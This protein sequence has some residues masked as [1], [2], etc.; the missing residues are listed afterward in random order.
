MVLATPGYRIMYGTSSTFKAGDPSSDKHQAFNPMI[1][2]IDFPDSIKYAIEQITTCN[3]LYPNI[4][5]DTKLEEGT[6]TFSCHFRDPILFS[7]LFTYKGLPTSWTGSGDTMTFDFSNLINKDVNIWV[8]YHVED[9]SGESNHLDVLLDGGELV[10]YKL[11][12]EGGP[13]IEEFEIKFATISVATETDS[14]GAYAI[15]IDDGFDDGSFDQTGVAEI[16]TVVAK[17]K[18]SL[19]NGQYFKLWKA[20]GSGGWTAYYAYMDVTGTEDGDPAPTGFTK[21]RCNI[22]GDTT[23]QNV[24][25]TITAAITA[26]SG[27]TAANGGGASET[28]TIT[29]DNTGDIKNIV[30]VDTTMTVAVLTQGVTALDGG[31]SL[32]DGDYTSTKCAMGS[33]AVVTFGGASFTDIDIQKF[34]MSFDTPKEPYYVSNSLIVK[35]RTLEVR[36]PWAGTITGQLTKGNINMAQPSTVLASKTTGTLKLEYATNK[37]IQFTN[38]YT[39]G[40]TAGGAEAGKSQEA[41]FTQQGGANS[42]A[43]YSW[44]GNEATDPSA[45]ITHTD[46]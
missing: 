8:Q 14:T 22:S 19:S 43:S 17:A 35:E 3:K 2:S 41:E 10:S 1:S 29:N 6:V 33:D 5:Y 21:I 15:D 13:I 20:D 46:I 23:A 11:S 38:A 45:M 30:D 36:G 27:L 18:A 16:S 12:F 34:E 37:Y 24:S 31:W 39:E 25:D 4:E 40:V 26:V 42:A 28:V 44:T 9:S 32:W 7:T